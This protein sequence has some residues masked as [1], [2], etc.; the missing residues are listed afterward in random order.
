MK[1]YG[2]SYKKFE[3]DLKSKIEIIKENPY[4]YQCVDKKKIDRR[5]II[6]KYIAF[7]KI[8]NHKVIILR[9]L[10]QKVNY[11]QKR[12]YKIKSKKQLEFK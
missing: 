12:I 4:L 9:I 5:F 1:F 10:S 11:N 6:Q 8:E 7:Y 3:E 2:S